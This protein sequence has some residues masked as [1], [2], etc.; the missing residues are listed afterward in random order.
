[1]RRL[2]SMVDKA[3]RYI[4]SNKKGPPLIKMQKEG[5]NMVD[6]RKSLGVKLIRWKIEKRV[7]ERI[8]HVLRMEDGRMVKSVMFGWL[9][10][11]EQRERVKG[12][13]RKTVLYWRK[14]IREA[15]WDITTIGSKTA[16]RKGWKAAVRER[17]KHLT[18]W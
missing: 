17:M 7:Y 6:V 10:N 15:G 18:E 16:D 4:W 14:L 5:V 13:K 9:K 2:Q 3:Y 12:S 11:L 8:G 1:M